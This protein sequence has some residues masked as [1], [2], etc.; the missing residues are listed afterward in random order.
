MAMRCA[1]LASGGGSNFQ[2]LIDR[3]TA[4]DL[5]VDFAVLIGNNSNATAFER[6]RNNG[7]PAVH[8]A[9][10]HF[11]TERQ[12]A[13]RLVEIFKEYEV[14]LIVLAG[15]MKKIPASIVSAYHNRIVN[16]HPALLPS[17][18]GKGLYGSKVHQA[19]L[20]YGAKVTGVTV[21]FIDEEYDHGPIILQEVVN[22]Q[23]DDTAESLARRV[24]AVEHQSYWR[25]IEAIAAGSIEVRGRR[26]YG[27][28]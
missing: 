20:D 26:V 5:H 16:I 2:A 21:H 18:G 14:D 22:V 1:V 6:A 12:Y 3:R 23:D 7:I 8:C 19:V 27:S 10:S 15:F 24:L 28:A 9:P 4:G 25:A 17:F 13:D 11:D